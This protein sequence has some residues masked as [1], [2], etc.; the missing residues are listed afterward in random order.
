MAR[1]RANE[2]GQRIATSHGWSKSWA[3]S[4][5]EYP[6]GNRVDGVLD[7]SPKKDAAASG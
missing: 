2:G 6:K 3:S 7:T 4:S 1:A 5:K